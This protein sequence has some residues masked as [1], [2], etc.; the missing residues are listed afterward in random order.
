[1]NFLP[2]K[3]NNNINYI[4]NMSI[5]DPNKCIA[6]KNMGKDIHIQCP[7][8]R[9]F[10]EFCG[11]HYKNKNGK[12]LRMD[13]LLPNIENKIIKKPKQTVLIT[14][15]NITYKNITYKNVKQNDN[16]PTLDR[17]YYVYDLKYSLK[18]YGLSSKGKR[19]ILI[20]RLSKFLKQIRYYVDNIEKVKLIQSIF[21]R[22]LV[23]DKLKLYGPGVFNRNICNNKTDFFSL[24]NINGIP[25]AYFY[26]YK[27]NSNFIYG[28]DIRSIHKLIK[29][30]Q[31][32]PYTREEFGDKIIEIVNKRIDIMKKLKQ[33]IQYEQ[34]KLTPE[35]K[36]RNKVITIFQ[37]I[38]DLGNYTNI[39]WFL[40]LRISDLKKY[41]KSL[42]ELWVY[43]AQL[44]MEARRRI[45]PDNNVLIISYRRICRIYNLNKL[46]NI[47]LDDIDKLVSSG[48]NQ[49]EK[50][51][52]GLY[53]LTG[54]AEVSYECAQ[55]LPWLVQ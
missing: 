39:T 43:R 7:C 27:D 29:M 22:K 23:L 24:E 20:E 30:K 6:R 1:M 9:K 14:Y 46:R 34:P 47:I 35:Q 37:K 25:I 5:I 4:D 52:G 33:S 45:V 36:L 10:G 48:I 54:L 17:K 11:R 51:L 8:K 40:K 42:L 15:K 32:N 12:V 41:Y 50:I 21:R 38:D 19:T 3:I 49:Q 2:E 31:P 13:Q 53:V 26:S 18:K 44:T 55:S 28:F 16:L